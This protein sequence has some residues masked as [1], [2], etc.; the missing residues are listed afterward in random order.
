[1]PMSLN[2]RAEIYKQLVAALSKGVKLAALADR[3]GSASERNSIKQKN[4]KLATEAARIRRIIQKDW[5]STA[6]GILSGIGDA[7]S[8]LQEQV[9]AIEATRKTGER[10]VKGLGYLDDLIRIAGKV[11]AVL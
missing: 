4:E 10:V 11:A 5:T 7:S 1:M 9:R 8:K 6:G 2:D 3:H